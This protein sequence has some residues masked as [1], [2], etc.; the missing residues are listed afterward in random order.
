[1]SPVYEEILELEPEPDPFSEADMFGQ[2][3]QAWRFVAEVKAPRALYDLPG[4]MQWDRIQP[5]PF[6]PFQES[7]SVRGMTDPLIEGASYAFR[8]FGRGGSPEAHERARLETHGFRDLTL[9]PFRKQIRLPG[10]PSTLFSEWIGTGSFTGANQTF[11][12]ADIQRAPGAL[13]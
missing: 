10:Q 1:V 8:F 13:R 6:S 5:L 7:L 9:M 12:F 4:K 11:E 2:G 3:Q